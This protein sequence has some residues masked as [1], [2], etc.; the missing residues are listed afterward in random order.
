MNFSATIAKYQALEI[1]Y[2]THA[3]DVER[4]LGEGKNVNWGGEQTKG[5]F[6]KRKLTNKIFLHSDLLTSLSSSQTP[7]FFTIGKLEL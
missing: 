3:G 5:E 4:V 1:V 2:H 7:L 6:Q